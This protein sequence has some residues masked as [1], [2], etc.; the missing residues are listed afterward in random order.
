[1]IGKIEAAKVIAKEQGFFIA[2]IRLTDETFNSFLDYLEQML[3]PNT[4]LSREQSSFVYTG[5]R[6]VK[7]SPQDMFLFALTVDQVLWDGSVEK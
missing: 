1:M 6:V 3:P 7:G 5:I 2:E 4:T